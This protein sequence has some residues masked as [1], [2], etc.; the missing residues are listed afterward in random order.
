MILYKIFAI[1]AVL[2]AGLFMLPASA[3]MASTAPNQKCPPNGTNWS[4]TG[5]WTSRSFTG[6]DGSTYALNAN[7]WGT[8]SSDKFTMFTTTTKGEWGFCA[9]SDP[10]GGWPYANEEKDYNGEAV[11]S[12]KT[13]ISTYNVSVPSN[14]GQWNV[15]YDIG[16]NGEVANGSNE[17]MFWVYTHG[18]STGSAAEGT[19][20]VDGQKWNLFGCLG[21]RRV[22]LVLPKNSTSGTIHVADLLH[23]LQKDHRTSETVPPSARLYGVQFGSEVH[24][25]QGH[26]LTFLYQKY[27]LNP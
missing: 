8:D 2:A 15:A 11:S 23:A 20:T 10:Y 26:T 7:Q 25:T 12:V 24:G 16:I 19:I 3:A 6:T 18:Q 22:D 4:S 27:T 17:V 13:L 5:S 14:Y 21:C 1:M 9:N